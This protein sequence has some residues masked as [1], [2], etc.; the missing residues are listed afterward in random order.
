MQK[1]MIPKELFDELEGMAAGFAKSGIA[2]LKDF[3]VDDMIG[4]N[5]YQEMT[6]YWWPT[7]RKSMGYSQRPNGVFAKSHCSAFA[8]TGSATVDGRPVIGHQTFTE[9]WNGQYFNIILDITPSSGARMIFQ[10]APGFV[11]SMTDFWVSGNGLIITE[12]TIVGYEG[13]D[14]TKMPEWV[15]VRQATQ[16]AKTIEEW[17][18]TMI[19]KNNGGYA[20]SWLLAD[21]KTGEIASLELGLIY[22]NLTVM[23]DGY[24]AGDNAPTDARI[25]NLECNDVGFSDVRQQT[26]ARRTRWPQLLSK[27]FGKINSSVGQTMLGDTWDPYLKKENPSSR[28]ICAHYDIDPQFYVS[29]P[30]A[31]WNVPFTPAGSVDGKLAT[32]AMADKMNMTAIFGRA[33][34]VAFDAPAFLKENP[35]WNWQAPYLKSRPSQPWTLF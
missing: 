1:E 23:S 8:A 19:Y 5:A 22:H 14:S 7:A 2:S 13:Y 15:R 3:T 27:N 20:N 31:V 34:G 16:H 18:N 9:F 10:A 4:W 26:G 12:T 33:D 17:A 21:T 35:Q 29:D 28:C 11:S 32:A 30:S 6:G 24:I 25:R